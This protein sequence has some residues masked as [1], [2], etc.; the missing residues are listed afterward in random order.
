MAKRKNQAEKYSDSL[1][2]SGKA[3]KFRRLHKRLKKTQK[4]FEKR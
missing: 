2:A 1:E 4:R 3:R